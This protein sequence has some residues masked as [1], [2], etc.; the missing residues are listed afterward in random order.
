MHAQLAAILAEKR[1]EVDILKR[2]GVQR[3]GDDNLP[4]IRDFKRAI[5][6][7]GKINLIA[8]IKFASPSA[9]HIREKTD[10]IAIGR[11]YEEAGAAAISLLTDT[12]FF[13]G[14]L[15]QLPGLKKALSLPIFR[16]DFIIDKV[17]VEESFVYG[18]DALL[19]IARIL[20]GQ[21]LKVLLSL[22]QEYGMAPLT[23]V[24]DRDDLKKAIDCGAQIIGINNRDL[25]TFDVSLQ[26]TI[27]LAPLIPDT[28]VVVSESGMNAE[29]DIRLLQRSGIHAVLVGSSL[30][31]SV[32][33]AKKTRELVEAGNEGS[34]R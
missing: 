27:D 19:L 29:K 7:P 26:T 23:E 5:S 16:K 6:K 9:G 32:D 34:Q 15:A 3:R 4:P 21:Q 24:H 18:A 11:I 20:S 17:Q 14:E 28:C 33:V 25:D 31:K 30:M 2:E 10:P 12:S 1:K 13:G 22:C 8:E